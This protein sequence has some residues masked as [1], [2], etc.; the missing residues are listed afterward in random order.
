M[1][2][3]GIVTFD[4]KTHAKIGGFPN[5]LGFKAYPY[6]LPQDLEQM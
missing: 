5:I 3:E 2:H 1:Q 4:K 6:H